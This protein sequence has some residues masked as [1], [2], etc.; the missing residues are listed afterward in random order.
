MSR[1]S[2]GIS[3]EMTSAFTALVLKASALFLCLSEKL[4]LSRGYLWYQLG[5]VTQCVL[6]SIFGN[7]LESEKLLLQEDISM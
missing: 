7:N 4:E 1:S 2:R 6:F 3:V 5:V